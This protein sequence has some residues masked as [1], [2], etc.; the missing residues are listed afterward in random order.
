MVPGLYR[1]LGRR[2][3]HDDCYLAFDR[4]RFEAFDVFAE[5]RDLVL[6]LF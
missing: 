1:M 5:K 2:E 3:A 6:V 4:G